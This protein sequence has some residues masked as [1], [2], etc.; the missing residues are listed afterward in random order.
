MWQR[1]GQILRQRQPELQQ[2]QLQQRYMFKYYISRLKKIIDICFVDK[3]L[4]F[5]KRSFEGRRKE[6]V[7][8]ITK[9]LFEYIC[10]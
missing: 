9:A 7:F 6:E 10:R 8:N 4:A 1:Q 3:V 5:T 2:Q